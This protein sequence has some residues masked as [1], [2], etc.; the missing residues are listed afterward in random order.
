MWKT[1][2]SIGVTAAIIIAL[3]LGEGLYVKHTFQAFE[4]RLQILLDKTEAETA[5]Y[6]DGLGVQE[7]W[8]SKK[9]RLHAWVPHTVLHEVDYQMNEAIGFLFL[10]DYENALPKVKVLL[11]L[12]KNI[13]DGYSVNFGNVF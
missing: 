5:S 2:I 1:F 10:N 6:D 13:P 7:F 9:H 11:G 12:S 4:M 3:C 8:E